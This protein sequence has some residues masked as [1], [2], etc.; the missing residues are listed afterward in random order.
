ML[1]S[2]MKWFTQLEPEEFDP[3]VDSDG[4]KSFLVRYEGDLVPFTTVPDSCKISVYRRAVKNGVP[5]PYVCITKQDL[6][7]IEYERKRYDSTIAAYSEMRRLRR[8]IR[9]PFS[10]EF[11]DYTG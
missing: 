10:Y 1:K 5:L 6:E 4:N 2:L 7:R 8:P 9:K 11:P 3:A